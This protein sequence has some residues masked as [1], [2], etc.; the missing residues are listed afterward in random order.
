[1]PSLFALSRPLVL[2]PGP[3]PLVHWLHGGAGT[4][5]QSLP[6]SRAPVGINPEDGYLCAHND[7]FMRYMQGAGVQTSASNSWHFG[8]TP[9]HDPF[10][11]GFVSP[12]PTDTVVNYTQRRYLWIHG[13]LLG[14]FP[15]DP[16]RVAIQGHSV[17]SAGAMALAK[18]F[19]DLFS[20]ATVFNN[21][22]LGPVEDAVDEL[23][24]GALVA[25]GV[26]L[27]GTRADALPTTLTRAGGEVVL[28]YELFDLVTPISSERDLPLVRSL[29][30]KHDENATMM[31][32]ADVVAQYRAA[33]SLALGAHLYW[34]ERGHGLGAIPAYFSSGNTPA[35]QTGRDDVL[36]QGRYRNDV[37]YPAFFNHRLHPDSRD[38]GD[39]TPGT[40]ADPVSS[41]DDWGTWGGFHDWA[42]DSI[43]DAAS[44]WEATIWLIA[45][46]PW[47]P[48]NCPFD[49]LT[50]DVAIRRPQAFLPVAGASVAWQVLGLAGDTLQRGVSE[51]RADGLVI[52]EGVVTARDPDRRRLRF[53]PAGNVAVAP[54]PGRLDGIEWSVAP[55]PARGGA[56]IGFRLP[57]PAP[58]RIVVV[59]LQ[60][61][62]VATLVEGPFA[63]GDHRVAW[64]TGSLPPGVYLVRLQA[65]P[66]T[67]TRRM[68][69]LP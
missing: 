36:Y 14:H 45:G 20:T 41:G 25:A 68:V 12:A 66:E 11:P 38:P 17:G 8:W 46:S 26:N 49:S 29:H 44:E 48:D 1:M 67:R 55:V 69:V 51:V 9:N 22:F 10:D 47:A 50:T 60:G 6:G 53:V 13:W 65:G 21:G 23:P 35:T 34:D 43:V 59:D 61:R 39:G 57:R 18:T 15:V 64:P 42:P 58:V 33:D 19:P 7:D 5:S 31:W 3:R 16:H 24:A 56:R 4:A 40:S 2:P 62:S 32:D 54:G 52:A 63:A 28:A 27:F 37:S 30:G